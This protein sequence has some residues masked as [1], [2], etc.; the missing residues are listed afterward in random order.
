MFKKNSKTGEDG[1]VAFKN[2]LK[3]EMQAAEQ[4]A[5]HR[6]EYEKKSQEDAKAAE[7]QAKAQMEEEARIAAEKHQ[8]EHGVYT[9]ASL[10]SMKPKQLKEIMQARHIPTVGCT[11]KDDFVNAILAAQDAVL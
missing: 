9:E 8:R 1:L 10:K 7:E 5:K 2:Q 6:E 3:G 11:E 4:M